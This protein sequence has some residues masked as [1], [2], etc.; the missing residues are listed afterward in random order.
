MMKAHHCAPDHL[1]SAAQLA[2]AAG[3]S[4][5]S[6]ANLQYGLLGAQ[7]NAELPTALPR[8]KSGT[9]ITTCSIATAEDQRSRSEDEWLWKMHAHIAQALTEIE[10]FGT[11]AG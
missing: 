3:Y 11:R 9:L 6:C 4:S 2:E 1:I 5:Y 10:E 7:L 8:R